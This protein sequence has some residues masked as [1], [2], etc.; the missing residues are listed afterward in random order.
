MV[1]DFEQGASISQPE[2]RNEIIQPLGPVK[3][4]ISRLNSNFSGRTC[5]GKVLGR[6]KSSLCTK[7]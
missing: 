3:S 2:A 1:L 6:G 7:L 4:L 5:F